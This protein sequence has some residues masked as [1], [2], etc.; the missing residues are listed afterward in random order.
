MSK[1]KTTLNT[2]EMWLKAQEDGKTYTMAMVSEEDADLAKIGDSINNWMTK[3][4]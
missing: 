4:K 3:Q 1:E 2:A